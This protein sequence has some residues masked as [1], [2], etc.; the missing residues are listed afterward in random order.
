LE[1]VGSWEG[2]LT[3]LKTCQ[4]DSAVE[5]EPHFLRLSFQ[6]AADSAVVPVAVVLVGVVLVGVVVVSRGLSNHRT[7]FLWSGVGDVVGDVVE[8]DVDVGP[9]LVF[10]SCTISALAMVQNIQLYATFW[11]YRV[12]IM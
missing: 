7:H 12:I 8:V 10:V 5:K 3:L 2:G 4:K 6:L 1:Y 9:S 11:N